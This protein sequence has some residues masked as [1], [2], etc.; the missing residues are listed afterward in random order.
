MNTLH[1]IGVHPKVY[2]AWF[3]LNKGTNIRVNTAVGM[4]D[5]AD[6][7]EVIG[8]GSAG[9]ALASQVNIDKGLESYF[10]G[11]V[12]EMN[13]GRVRLQPLSFQDDIAR[14]VRG[15]KG[16]VVGNVKMRSMMEE[17]QLEVHT[18]KTGFIVLG[19]KKYKE[20]VE[21]DLGASPITFG[22]FVTRSKVMDKYLGDMIH[23]DGLAASVAATIQDRAGKVKA[24]GFEVAAIVE[25]FRM[26]AVGGL[27]SAWDLWN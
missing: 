19:G 12:D 6:V 2:R 27:M 24:A 20:A 25:D 16:A 10:K 3:N 11:S 14:A 7:G 15:V 21:K 17:K 22:N 23:T 18:D 13:Y 26:Q 8:Q 4:S 1:Q 9:G 5:R